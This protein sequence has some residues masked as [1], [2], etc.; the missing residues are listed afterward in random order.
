M[1][2]VDSSLK[3][4]PPVRSKRFSAVPKD[5]RIDRRAPRRVADPRLRSPGGVCPSH[6]AQPGWRLRGLSL[7]GSIAILAHALSAPMRMLISAIDATGQRFPRL[8]IAA[9]Q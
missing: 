2:R 1:L 8:L 5:S 4:G 7:L 6:H 3:R 9:F